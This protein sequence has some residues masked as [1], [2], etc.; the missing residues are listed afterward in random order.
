MRE[1]RVETQKAP[2]K[3]LVLFVGK[4]KMRAVAHK[5]MAFQAMGSAQTKRSSRSR[6]LTPILRS[7]SQTTRVYRVLSLHSSDLAS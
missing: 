3:R 2:A 1:H 4:L 7:L 6:T 5:L